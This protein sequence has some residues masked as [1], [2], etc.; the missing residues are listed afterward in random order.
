MRNWYLSLMIV[1][2]QINMMIISSIPIKY[3]NELI[4]FFDLC[5][6]I[7][8]L[9]TSF[10]YT[11]YIL[12]NMRYDAIKSNDE[13]IQKNM[14]KIIKFSLKILAWNKVNSTT[15]CT[16]SQYFYFL[17]F[18]LLCSIT[19][20]LFLDCIYSQSLFLNSHSHNLLSIGHLFDIV[21]WN[22]LFYLRLLG[23]RAVIALVISCV[24]GVS[25]LVVVLIMANQFLA[26]LILWSI[27]LFWCSMNQQ[28]AYPY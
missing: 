23:C 1:G 8:I 13:K 7:I 15:V 12:I 25:V 20:H 17:V 26:V 11:T 2:E 18:S 22:H 6:P 10:P 14:Q 5:I 4:L 9:L 28:T 27:F 3:S 24:I 16:L 19:S 21:A